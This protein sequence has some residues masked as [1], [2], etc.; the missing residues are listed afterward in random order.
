MKIILFL[1]AA[2]MGFAADFTVGTA[3]AGAGKRATGFIQVPAGVDAGTN[4]PVI[5]IHGAKPGPTLAVVAGAHGTEYASIIALEK[6]SPDPA[7][8][9]GTLIILPLVNLASFA[10]K[11]PHLNP[12]DGKNMNRMYPGKA[13]GTQTER[14]SWVIGREVVAKCDYMI[15]L[16]GGDLDENL[17]RYSYWPRTGKDQFDATTRGMVLAFG[18]D[19]VILQRNQAP[20]VPGATSIS[21]FAIDSGKPT[22]IAEAGHAGTT[23]AADID[24]LVRGCENVMRH[25]K[26]LPGTAAAVEHPVWIG[27]ITTVKSDLD[28]IFYP[29]AVPEAYVSQG[30]VIGYLTDYFGNKLADVTAPIAGVVAYICSVPSMKKGDTVA[31]IGE[32]AVP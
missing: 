31:N 14:A 22:I 2:G 10:Q 24:A 4:I 3:T 7:E 17:R 19:H 5:V 27:P 25:L 26:M 32:I 23:D 30:M 21:R 11:V 16:H 13:D 9:S 8:L 1:L 20:A 18:L 29:L 6:L 12:V 28:G 15:D